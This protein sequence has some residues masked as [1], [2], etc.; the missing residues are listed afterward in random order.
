MITLF[1]QYFPIFRSAAIPR[2][3]RAK[4]MWLCKKAILMK[5]IL[6]FKQQIPLKVFLEVGL[7]WKTGMNWMT[8]F[9]FL[10]FMFRVISSCLEV[11]FW[12]LKDPDKKALVHWG[13]IIPIHQGQCQGV[14]YQSLFD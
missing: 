11:T 9:N 1:S 4:Q 14:N 5:N 12:E 3:A 10:F 2:V 8:S 13:D 7:Y 6:T